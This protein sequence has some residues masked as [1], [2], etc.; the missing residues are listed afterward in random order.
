M[1]STE[2]TTIWECPNCDKLNNTDVFAE[3]A[4]CTA[5]AGVFEWSEVDILNL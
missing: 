1:L 2:D 4:V 5:C 3:Q